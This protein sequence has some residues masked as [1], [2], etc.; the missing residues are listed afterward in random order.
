MQNR[1]YPRPD[2]VAFVSYILLTYA[3]WIPV[4]CFL[5]KVVGVDDP[6]F[7]DYSVACPILYAICGCFMLRGSNWAR[8]LFFG[9]CIPILLALLASEE[10]P[11]VILRSIVPLLLAL[12]LLTRGANRFF[13]GRTTLFK[14]RP[15]EER[16]KDYVKPR[17]GRYDY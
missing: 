8:I 7:K 2:S 17:G 15:V 1:P 16:P 4:D 11:M 6:L 14:P 9:A 13:I 12:I 10:R 3:V 5:R